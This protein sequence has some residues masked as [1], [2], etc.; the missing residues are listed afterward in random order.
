MIQFL[1]KMF[2]SEKK[3]NIIGNEEL[4]SLL[5]SNIFYWL[6][7]FFFVSEGKFMQFKYLLK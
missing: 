1:Q 6:N 5:F 7:I 3:E 2:L 4:A